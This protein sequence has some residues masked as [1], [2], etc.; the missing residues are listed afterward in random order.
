MMRSSRPVSRRSARAPW[1][2]LPAIS[3]PCWKIKYAKANLAEV[4]QGRG[5][6]EEASPFV[7]ERL[8]GQ[9]VPPEAERLVD[10]WRG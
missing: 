3:T 4:R 8:T 9:K 5:A 10:P 1:Q 2:A 7:R 6:L